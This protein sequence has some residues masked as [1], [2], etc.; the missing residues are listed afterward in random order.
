[1]NCGNIGWGLSVRL[2][3][4]LWHRSEKS[5]DSS[6]TD[7]FGP[8]GTNEN[9]NYMCLTLSEPITVMMPREKS[10]RRRSTSCGFFSPPIFPIF[11]QKDNRKRR[12]DCLAKHSQ[13]L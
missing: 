13:T 1:M 8:Q 11:F 12:Q 2:T 3:A 7:I 5:P 9:K 10:F 6:S 4:F